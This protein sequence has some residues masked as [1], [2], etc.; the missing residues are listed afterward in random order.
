MHERMHDAALAGPL[1]TI[2]SRRDHRDVVRP[3]LKS[4]VVDLKVLRTSPHPDDL[5]AELL[6]GPEG[7]AR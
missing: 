6:A 2:R 5:P 1:V 3:Q 7:G 4:P